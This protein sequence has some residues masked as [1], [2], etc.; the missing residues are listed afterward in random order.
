MK[1]SKVRKALYSL[2]KQLNKAQAKLDQFR[3]N[4]EH[5]DLMGW[6]QDG[7]LDDCNKLEHLITLATNQ[8]EKL[9]D[10]IVHLNDIKGDE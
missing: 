8:L 10:A 9:F 7:L 1:P 5:L 3:D 6:A 4:S 2:E